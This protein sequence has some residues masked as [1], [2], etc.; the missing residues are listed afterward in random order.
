M[1]SCDSNMPPELDW[2]VDLVFKVHPPTEDEK[3]QGG[4]PKELKLIKKRL[5]LSGF[6]NSQVTHKGDVV[7]IRI[8]GVDASNLDKAIR[9]IMR[10]GT[11]MIF[12]GA[13]AK[14]QTAYQQA[15]VIPAGHMVI[16]DMAFH[17]SMGD[18]QADPWSYPAIVVK[19][20]AILTETDILDAWPEPDRERD[21]KTQWRTVFELTK[22]AAQRY[23]AA[24]AEVARMR[25]SGVLVI[26]I[27][28]DYIR[29]FKPTGSVHRE[30]RVTGLAS[31]REARNIGMLSLGG[32]YSLFCRKTDDLSTQLKAYPTVTYYGTPKSTGK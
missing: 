19:K 8:P 13:D 15:R 30:A 23:D 17:P 29:T 14:A 22:G 25:P 16:P 2:G 11:T 28:R 6:M 26:E 31:E 27:D 32:G 1:L 20:E 7:E 4:I 9:A 21:P 10:N 24:V 18:A 3:A 12:Q 5:S